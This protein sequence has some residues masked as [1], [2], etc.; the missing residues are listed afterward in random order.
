MSLS[1]DPRV[2][3]PPLWK[4]LHTIT[5]KYPERI[6]MSDVDD[7]AIRNKVRKIFE[8]LRKTIPCKAC[9]YSY[10][11]F[12]KRDGV[13]KYLGGRDGLSRWLYRL[14]NKVNGKLRKQELERFKGAL[15]RLDEYSRVRRISPKEYNDIKGRLKSQIMI[16]GKDPLYVDVKKRYK[17][18]RFIK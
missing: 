8:E 4:R 2:W 16:T 9:R 5:F 6:D 18:A 15:H 17:Y 1:S 13:E 7:V 12:F 11:K 14:H 3:G 10:R